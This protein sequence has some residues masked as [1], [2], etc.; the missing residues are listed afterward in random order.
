MANWRLLF[1]VTALLAAFSAP[2]AYAASA[3]VVIDPTTLSTDSNKPTISGTASSTKKI[4]ISI[5]KQGASKASYKKSNIRVKDGVWKV[6]V[7]KK[8]SDGMYDV[9]VSGVMGVLVIGDENGNLE[10]V[11]TTLN[12]SF[13][14]LLSG[15]IARAGT[16][17]PVSYLK[18]VNT[19]K[20]EATLKGFN[21]RQTGSADV[22]SIIGLTTVDGT[23]TIRGSSGGTEG[24]T[25]FSNGLAFV[26]MEAQFAPGEMRLFTIK[27]VITSAISS[28][29]GK[30][31]MLEVASLEGNSEFTGTFPIRGTTWTLAY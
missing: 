8:L 30:Q 10:K 16:A 6:K 18:V 20:V 3:V 24:S 1:L 27:A 7:S 25:L 2:A 14:P 15:G 29:V 17:V 26:P 13:V 9:N 12:V 28:H 31:L 19:G 5:T 21:V 4:K 22:S 23:G 11:N